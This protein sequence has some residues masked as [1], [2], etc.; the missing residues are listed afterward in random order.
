MARHEDVCD[1]PGCTND[2][3][4][5][6]RGMC[7]AC[8]SSWYYWNR[9]KKETRG[10]VLARKRKLEFWQGRLDWLYAPSGPPLRKKS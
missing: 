7:G 9:R 4:N 1:V 5:M 10:A 3:S 2:V 8:A 6:K